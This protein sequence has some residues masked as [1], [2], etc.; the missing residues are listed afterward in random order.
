M[1][2][3]AAKVRLGVFVAVGLGLL[4]L[5]A[6]VV[7]GK[8]LVNRE[9]IYYIEFADYSVSGLQ[10]GGTVKYRGIPVG[11]VEDIRIHPKDVTRVILT[12]SVAKGTPIKADSEAILAF[13]GI[14]GVKAVEIQGGSNQS[15]PLKPKGYIKAGKSSLEDISVKALTIAEKIDLIATNLASL[16]N[17]ENRENISGI[18]QQSNSLLTDA[19]GGLSETLANLNVLATN[20]AALSQKLNTSVDRVNTILTAAE[21]DSLVANVALISAQLRDA[22][23]ASLIDELNTTTVKAGTLV[24][25]LDRTLITNR[26]NLSE[27]LESLR[28]ASENLNEFSRQIADQPSILLRGNR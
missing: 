27:T 1:V 24:T 25:N 22:R 16:T 8:S 14:T 12:V 10:T 23:I 19:K 6:F 18:L 4:A 15:A 21:L 13:V 17:A 26:A 20:T 2:S 28:E 7:A 11:R 5:F 9:D 3:K